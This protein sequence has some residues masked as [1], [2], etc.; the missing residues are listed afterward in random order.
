MPNKVSFEELKAMAEKEEP[1]EIHPDEAMCRLGP[2]F[3]TLKDAKD[4]KAFLEEL[5]RVFRQMEFG[6]I[7]CEGVSVHTI[8]GI[9][10]L[11]HHI[12]DEVGP[13]RQ[14][15]FNKIIPWLLERRDKIKKKSPKDIVQYMVQKFDDRQKEW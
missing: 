9:C 11:A 10:Q 15:N 5:E 7:D 12:R 6:K 2:A 4:G 8:I 1:E 14:K 3:K 13:S